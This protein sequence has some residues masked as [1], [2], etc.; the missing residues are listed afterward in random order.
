MKRFLEDNL[1]RY[2]LWPLLTV[3]VILLCSVFSSSAYAEPRRQKTLEVDTAIFTR[4]D[5][6]LQ[7]IVVRPKKQKYSKKNNPAVDLMERIRATRDLGNPEQMPWYSYDKYD[8][9][10][11]G[12]NDFDFDAN[13]KKNRWSFLQEYADTA[14]ATGKPILNLSLKEKLSTSIWRNSPRAHRN[15]ERGVRSVGIDEAFEQQNIRKMLDDALREVNIY[16]NDI[17]L[18]QNRFV[19]PLSAIGADYYKYFITDTLDVDGIKCVELS[20][21]PRNPESFSFNGKLY[22]DTTDSAYFVKKVAMRVPRVLNLNFVDNIFISQTF[23]RDSIGKRHKTVDDMSLELQLVSGTP[24][25]YGRRLTTYGNFSYSPRPDMAE[26]YD[27]LA[28]NI[29]EKGSEERD[30]LFWANLRP[31]ELTRQEAKMDGMLQRMRSNKVFYIGEK[32]IRIM[33]RQYVGTSPTG[34]PS[35][36]DIG[37]LLSSVSFGDVQG[38]RLRLGGVTTAALNPH[39]FGRGYIAYGT[40]DRKFKYRLEGEYSFVEK[41]RHSREFPINSL[42]LSHEYDVD[43]IGQ[44]YVQAGNDALFLSIARMQ[45]I[46][47][48]YRRLSIAEYNLELENNFSFGLQLRHQVQEATPWVQFRRYDGTT[49]SRFSQSSAKITLRF[50]PGEVFTQG[51]YNRAPI[52][53]DAPIFTLSHEYGPKG[54]LG[55]PFGVNRTEGSVFKRI[56]FSSFGYLDVLAKAGISW[57]PTPYT[58]LLWANAN[59]SYTLQR[60]TFSL[61][62]PMEFAAE[63]YASIDMTYWMNGLILNR[64]PLI[65]KLKLREVLTFQGYLGGLSARSNP[66]KNRSLYSF[67]ADALCREMHGKPYMEIGV[68]IDNIARI[69]RLDYVWRLSYRNTPGAP[70]SGL[71][72]SLHF[73]F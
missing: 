4:R 1:H 9:I 62:N 22:I 38:M 64:L 3:M 24:S 8:K 27:R 35:K 60:E 30:S 55:A 12:L 41:K 15:V 10:I 42:R 29:Q 36:F 16:D 70:D 21:A 59:V 6:E 45:S 5:A 28:T 20:F 63:R 13:Q 32:L 44:N 11:L 18:M 26:Y 73:S 58:S 25:F 31:V 49:D 53:M 34:T 7:E 71:R 57:T 48:T 69:F 39:W 54:L 52:N 40:K 68:G 72:G 23:E 43:K 67:P 51:V 14:P 46:L 66:L 56:W 2:I 61:L 47:V 33:A 17:T 65:K 37:P 50:A 19:S